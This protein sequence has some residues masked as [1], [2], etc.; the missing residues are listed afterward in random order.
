[1]LYNRDLSW[2]G[3]NFRVLQ[4]AADARVPLFERLKFL[5]IFSSNLDEFFRVRYPSVVAMSKLN[6]KTLLQSSNKYEENLPEKV[7]TEINR[8][9]QV[10]S[11]IIRQLID[12]LGRENIC[13]YYNSQIKSQHTHEI[14]EIF[15]SQVLS[16]I[17]PLFLDANLSEKFIPENGYLYFIVTLKNTTD[18]TI[19]HA[20]VNIPSERLPRFF[21]LS[22]IEDKEYVIFIDDII[23]ENMNCLFPGFDISGIYSIKFNRDAEL[24]LEEEYDIDALGKVEKQLNKR[25]YNPPTRFLY[26]TGMPRNV[27]LFLASAFNIRHEEMFEGGRYH[28]LS[29]FAKFPTYNKNLFY[30]KFKPLP[31]RHEMDCGDIFNLLNQRDVLLHLPYESYNTVLAFFNQAAVDFSVTDIYITLYRVAAESHIVNALISAAKNGKNVTAFV[32]LKARFD[33][34]NNIQWSRKMKEAGVKIIYSMASIKVH[35]KI[36]L[37]KKKVNNQV[38]NYAI[39]STGNF[40]EVT[41]RFY[42]DHVL[43]TTDPIITSEILQLCKYLAK[44]KIDKLQFDTLYV[45]QFNM[46]DKFEKLIDLEIQK[47]QQ[48]KDGLIRIKVNNL[49]EPSMIHLLYKASIAG[50]QVQLLIRSVCC[51][52]PGIEGLSHNITVKRIVD[53]YLEHSR[54]FIFGCDDAAEVVMGS[55]DWM[56]RNLHRRIEVCVPVKDKTC[57]QELLDY[58]MLQ[59]KD[60]DKAV[61]LNSN[62]ENQKDRTPNVTLNAQTSIYNYLLNRK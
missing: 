57:R 58:F 21:S 48:G 6:K 27:Q 4:E 36:A 34:A 25:Q 30:P 9:L 56:N 23:R 24:R 31:F 38:I 15:L 44:N 40:H 18:V 33:E 2:L 42:T 46:I 7:Q 62:L 60:T 22:C 20:V 52:V 3:F 41:A 13:L 10:Y 49:E 39:L 37:I 35:S 1:M 47:V 19:Q 17:Q 5:S 12:E 43:M 11:S 14:R 8:Q 29:D 54:I 59:W 55:A 28:N 32:E 26:E 53:R 61:F 45:S 50:V 16:F 51:L